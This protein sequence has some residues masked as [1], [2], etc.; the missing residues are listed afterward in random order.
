MQPLQMPTR[1]AASV[2]PANALPE[3]PRPQ[4]VRESWQ[5]LNGLWQYAITA[6]DAG[7]PSRYD[8][9]ILVPYP[10]ESGLS[11]VAKPLKEDQLL[12]YR[13]VISAEADRDGQRVLL[14][15]GAVDFR[16]TLYVN[17]REIGTHIGGYQG[18]TFDITDTLK[19][20]D[21]E[22]ILKVSDPGTKGPY[23]RG[24]QSGSWAVSGIWQTVWLER[25]PRTYIEDLKITPN[26]DSSQLQ[27]QVKISGESA[28]YVVRAIARNSVQVV[29]DQPV[30]GTTALR[31]PNP[32]LWSPDDPFL[33][34]LDVRL[35]KGGK[36]VDEVK[37]Y[38]G[39]RKIEIRKDA[40]G[41]D[42]I[43]LNGR[44]TYNLGL[45]DQ[46][47]WPD[48]IY[49][50]PTDEAL[51]FDIEAAKAM[52]FNTLRKHVKIDAERW[53]YHCDKLGM[54]V[55]QDMPHPGG[56]S[57]EARQEF[58][59]E[60][61]ANLTQLHN[62]PSIVTWV[63]FNEGWRIYDQARLAPWM[64]ALDPSRLFDGYSGGYDMHRVSKDMR[65]MD[66]VKRRELASDIEALTAVI[67]AAPDTRPEN[68]IASDV[69]DFHHYP[70]PSMPITL[71]GKARVVGENGGIG[72][73]VEGHLW[74]QQFGFGYKQVTL[75]RFPAA[76]ADIIAK[77]KA[78]E[79]QGVS[80]SIY[81]QPFDTE[82][83]QNGLMTYDRAVI[84]IPLDE[85]AR[86]N[87]ELVPPSKSRD[88]IAARIS[89]ANAD[90]TP[91]PQRYAAFVARYDK[92]ER[93]IEFLKRFVS[94][95]LRQKDQAR[96]TAA[97][98]ELIAGLPEPYSKDAWVFINGMT[99]TS[100]DKGFELLRTR[101]EQANAVLGENAAQKSIRRII[102]GEAV[103]PLIARHQTKQEPVE[104][105]ELEKR[106]SGKY[107]PL[108]AEAVNEAAMIHAVRERD[109]AS[110][111]QY[112][113]RY[114][115]T[116][117]PRSEY[118]IDTLSYL[119]FEHVTDPKVLDAAT[120]FFGPALASAGAIDM[121]TYA[122]LLYKAGHKKEAV[123]WQEK[124]VKLTEGRDAS[125]AATLKKMKTGQR[126]WP[127]D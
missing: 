61:E 12:W 121:D 108:G 24:K 47:F 91:E 63:L 114:L 79:A 117:A 42:R 112:Y 122:G 71:P 72:A 89:I 101:T 65:K 6:Q 15:F 30:D 2:S 34:D 8:G 40:K 68:W 107:G 67:V 28:G 111:G 58:E 16:A 48:G 44:Y 103:E 85:I 26:V 87:S 41:V 120:R 113:V 80:A 75:D 74:N 17:D 60:V 33:Y 119:V 94:L 19:P 102:V 69:V 93:E 90:L 96:A 14:H 126:T 32:R 109:W 88:A 110:Y 118:A 49:T 22:L 39:M 127:Q 81:T 70:D 64:K 124:A 53:Y 9:E 56:T 31:I 62:H 95:A 7:K 46:A 77:N 97:G 5:N 10:L 11:G 36:V 125:L 21:N 73:F 76:Y 104:W 116:A 51:K 82:G 98:S 50:A 106:L 115:A 37:S 45:L 57:A 25:V 83:E 100:K 3:Y 27:L 55:W 66:P 38:F 18:F 1:W 99:R 78:L 35:L 29:A 52:G 86:I 54:L 59:R 92:G 105:A 23:P 20:A 13:R 84:K 4:L 123:E 43:F